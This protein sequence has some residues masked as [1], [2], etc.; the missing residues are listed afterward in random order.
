M[1]P[2]QD[3]DTAFTMPFVRFVSIKN[4]LPGGQRCSGFCRLRFRMY[5][6]VGVPQPPKGGTTNNQPLLFPLQ[7]SLT[8]FH[9]RTARTG[10]T[11]GT[12]EGAQSATQSDDEQKC[13][14]QDQSKSR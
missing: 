5:A 9:D 13:E 12:A 7:E 8:A 1:P 3:A 2:A 14:P 10:K 11:L 4:A 6:V